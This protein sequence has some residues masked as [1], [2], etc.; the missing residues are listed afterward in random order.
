ME[1]RFPPAADPAGTDIPPDDAGPRAGRGRWLIAIPAAIV[2]GFLF[3]TGKDVV[4]KGDYPSLS[5]ALL[6]LLRGESNSAY[7]DP[8][9]GGTAV[10]SR[11][12]NRVVAWGADNV[13]L[14]PGGPGAVPRGFNPGST[15]SLA[16]S[17]Q[18]PQPALLA[19][20]RPVTSHPGQLA[21]SLDELGETLVSSRG[22]QQRLPGQAGAQ[23]LQ[24]PDGAASATRGTLGTD[25]GALDPVP[26][27]YQPISR[28][29]PVTPATAPALQLAARPV[30]TA[31]A[32][33]IQAPSPS[34][35]PQATVHRASLSD[36]ARAARAGQLGGRVVADPLA[37]LPSQE[38]AQ[39]APA[40]S[41]KITGPA[42]ASG[43]IPTTPLPG[44][45]PIFTPLEGPKPEPRYSTAT[46]DR[47]NAGTAME[48]VIEEGAPAPKKRPDPKPVAK[49]STAAAPIKP[50]SPRPGESGNAA[51]A[52]ARRAV[53]SSQPP[54]AAP[55][56]TPSVTQAA[57]PAAIPPVAMQQ[58]APQSLQQ[59]SAGKA[60]AGPPRPP[61]AALG[62]PAGNQ[63]SPP[64]FGNQALMPAPL[65][66]VTPGT[67]PGEQTVRPTG[68]QSGPQGGQQLEATN[69]ARVGSS[70]AGAP[71]SLPGGHPS[72]ADV[73]PGGIARPRPTQPAPA[74][75]VAEAPAAPPAAPANPASPPEAPRFGDGPPALL[76]RRPVPHLSYTPIQAPGDPPSRPRAPAYDY[77]GQV[78]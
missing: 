55:P 68:S 57:P 39:V 66:P 78:Q 37:S 69:Q 18:P 14:G 17:R 19:Q 20:T 42:A 64:L 70:A 5:G 25:L 1:Q 62:A 49:P 77:F 29:S 71:S 67:L 23:G 9:A 7:S 75:P 10:V 50:A 11:G 35:A 34:A 58:S 30:G 52:P 43:T 24:R 8:Q 32:P 26:P 53:A 74:A 59:G 41:P 54:A 40:I 3:S 22:V 36:P 2:G 27:G 73:P 6:P 60:P 33:A 65:A 38:V 76:Q 45:N 46:L 16:A 15:A 63:A 56:V 21:S 12:G 61:A 44:G 48:P 31:A 51:P 28:P 13:A 47:I 72:M 4:A